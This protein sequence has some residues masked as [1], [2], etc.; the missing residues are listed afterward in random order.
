MS[1]LISQLNTLWAPRL[2]SVLRIITAFLFLQHGTAKLFG[3]PHVAFFDE[4]SLFSLIGFAG[5]L[6]AVG[7]LLLVLGLFTR[8]VAFILSG[9]MAFA[10]FIGHAPKG[11]FPLLNNGE[12]AILFCFIFLY[13]VAAGGGAW[14][15]DRRL[16]R[17]KPGC[18]W[19]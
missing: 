8:L 18:D 11:L 9:E 3:F 16:C 17:G 19:V 7:G 6:E 5:V 1:A 2:L 10:Y 14:S 12:P 13:L 15:L 4:L